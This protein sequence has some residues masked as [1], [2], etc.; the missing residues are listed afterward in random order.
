MFDFKFLVLA[1]NSNNWRSVENQLDFNC[2]MYDHIPE[3]V[4]ATMEKRCKDLPGER[5]Q[6]SKAWM[7][8]LIT[9]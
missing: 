3:K 7:L 9:E 6:R 2:F 8:T 1:L 5:F 4:T